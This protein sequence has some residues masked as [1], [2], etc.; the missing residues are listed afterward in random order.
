M[1]HD[2]P[3]ELSTKDAMD[4]FD[5]QPAGYTEGLHAPPGV[6]V[7][8]VDDIQSL[9][10]EVAF[11]TNVPKGK[12]FLDVGTLEFNEHYRIAAIAGY[13][14]Q[15]ENDVVDVADIGNFEC[16]L[17]TI[18]V[19]GMNDEVVG[20]D[21]PGQFHEDSLIT[22]PSV[23]DTAAGGGAGSGKTTDRETFFLIP[24][25]HLPQTPSTVVPG[26]EHKAHT[27]VSQAVADGITA[28]PANAA[29]QFDVYYY[30][31]EIEEEDVD[32]SQHYRY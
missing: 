9:Q 26:T 23:I 31:E 3:M 7:G 15:L 19:I 25:L 5:T 21:T 32:Y 28:G 11:S 16:S 2:D 24:E 18:N 20:F 29:I 17:Q 30:L 14:E 10:G 6:D 4:R 27:V 8:W 13:V 12:E 22:T 1:A